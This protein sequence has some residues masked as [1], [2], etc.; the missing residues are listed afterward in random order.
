MERVSAFV[1]KY[2]K[3]YLVAAV[4]CAVCDRIG[5]VRINTP[6]GTFTFFSLLFT[7]VIAGLLGQDILKVFTV[8]ESETAG[9][10]VLVVLAPFMAKMGVS[11]GANLSK[12]VAV[13][14]ALILQEFGNL[15]TIFLSLPLALLLGL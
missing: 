3:I 6:I 2:W 10:L 12:L 1:G 13:S 9:A 8:E 11:A 15:G 14:P 4:L 5:T 7:T